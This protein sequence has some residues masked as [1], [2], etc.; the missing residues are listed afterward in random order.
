MGAGGRR[1]RLRINGGRVAG[2]NSKSE[3]R[4]TYTEVTED[5]EF[6]EKRGEKRNPRPR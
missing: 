6:A 3:K 4:R 2:R 1:L 5:A